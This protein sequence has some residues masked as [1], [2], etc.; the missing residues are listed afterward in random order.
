MLGYGA[1]VVL[2]AVIYKPFFEASICF[3]NVSM[4]A[5]RAR[6]LINNIAAG[7]VGNVVFA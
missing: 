6:N 2:C 1:S 3:A 5:T 7:C 4:A